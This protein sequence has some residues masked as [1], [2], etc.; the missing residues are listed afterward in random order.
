MVTA[1]ECLAQAKELS[2]IA[3]RQ[4]PSRKAQTLLVAERWLD[5]AQLVEHDDI[6]ALEARLRRIASGNKG[7]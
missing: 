1:D 6:G 7:T 5:L 4:E 3:E 2:R